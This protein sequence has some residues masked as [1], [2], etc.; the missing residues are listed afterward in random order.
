MAMQMT[1]AMSC[2][3]GFELTFE[4]RGVMFMSVSPDESSECPVRWFEDMRPPREYYRE[5]SAEAKHTREKKTK[6]R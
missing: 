1:P 2:T 4:A 5:S 6:Y 3:H